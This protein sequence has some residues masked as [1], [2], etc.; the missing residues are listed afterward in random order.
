[1]SN[2]KTMRRP[3]SDPRD[4]QVPQ[5]AS[6][7]GVSA[8]RIYNLI[9]EGAPANNIGNA[10]KPRYSI[11][12]PD[13]IEWIR[14]RD[15]I[16]SDRGAAFDV[17]GEDGGEV[18]LKDQLLSEQ[19]RK[20]RAEAE[21][22]ERRLGIM[23]GRYVEIEIAREILSRDLSTLRSRL[24]ALPARIAPRLVGAKGSREISAALEGEVNNVIESLRDEFEATD[25]ASER[26]V[27][28]FKGG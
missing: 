10:D 24:M 22:Q 4:V 15:K 13:F 25:E 9:S 20:T 21:V 26:T 12:A 18:P 19:I 14:S 23:D 5:M 16:I 28:D 27:I 11:S 17:A 1:M 7:L 2:V 8:S 6:I 3:I